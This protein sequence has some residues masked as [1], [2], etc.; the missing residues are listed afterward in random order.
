[1]DRKRSK[2]R[3]GR[4]RVREGRRAVSGGERAQL[5]MKH[6]RVG[7]ACARRVFIAGVTCA[8]TGR[9]KGGERGFAGCR[10]VVGWGRGGVQCTSPEEES[11]SKHS[12]MIKGFWDNWQV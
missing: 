2:S 11:H 9:A 12:Q 7:S 3:E 1:M 10:R 4:G 5:M 6:G 8:C